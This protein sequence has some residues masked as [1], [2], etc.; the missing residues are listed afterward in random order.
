[1]IFRNIYLL[2]VEF[3]AVIA[4]GFVYGWLRWQVLS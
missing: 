3:G 2:E 1:M 4:N